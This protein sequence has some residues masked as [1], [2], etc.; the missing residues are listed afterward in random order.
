MKTTYDAFERYIYDTLEEAQDK[1][2]CTEACSLL[3]EQLELI[4]Q[5]MEAACGELYKS[6]RDAWRLRSGYEVDWAYWKGYQDCVVLLKRLA[7]I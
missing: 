3:D 2:Y 4:G 5:Q 1:L 7:V 6:Y